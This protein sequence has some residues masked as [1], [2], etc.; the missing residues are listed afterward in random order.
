MAGALSGPDRAL[1]IN[2]KNGAQ[3][4]VDRHNAANPDCQVAI[5]PFDTEGDPQ[6]AIGVA[7]SIVDDSSIVGL[8]GPAFSGETRAT[9]DVFNRAGLVAITASATNITLSEQGWR[10]FL[11]ALSNDG[12]QGPAVASYLKNTLGHKKV[13][14]VEDRTDYGLG[15]A[16]AVRETL[17]RVAVPDCNISVRK[18]DTDFSA[19]VAHIAS[20]A[21]DSVFYSGYY[22]EAA[23]FVRQMRDYGVTAT[24]ASGDGTK[25]AEFVKQAGGAAKDALVSC[26]C[27][28]FLGEFSAEY[29]RKFGVPPGTYPPRPTT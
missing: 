24:F 23:L 7:P 12:V 10:T 5:K 3:L 8:I 16:T 4:A 29:S 15:L 28:P 2:I 6:M 18:G 1:G 25:D 14:V 11:R 19:A 20:V 22:P 21:P 17:G 27:L 13:C 26:P 9:G